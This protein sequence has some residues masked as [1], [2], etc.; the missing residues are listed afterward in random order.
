MWD[1]ADRVSKPYKKIFF[2]IFFRTFGI[3]LAIEDLS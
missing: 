1:A 2:R 3:F